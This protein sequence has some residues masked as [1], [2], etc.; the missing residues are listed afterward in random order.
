MR[1]AKLAAAA[2]DLKRRSGVAAPFSLAFLTDV[3]RAPDPL[4]IARVLPEGAAVILRDYG[5]PWRAALA[6]QLKSVCA[7]RGVK[8]IIGADPELAERIGADG[9]HCPRWFSPA[10]PVSEGMIV[11]VS[12]HDATELRRAAALN[13]DLALLSPA[14]PTFSHKGAECLGY[15]AFRRLAAGSPVPVLALG[16]VDETNA[17]RLASLNVAGL[18]AISAFFG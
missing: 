16:G 15:D 9:I 14:F 5:L 2:N 4:L 1:A 6:A 17:G 10:E 11:T 12:A 8:L 3:R 18:A 13:A 7:A